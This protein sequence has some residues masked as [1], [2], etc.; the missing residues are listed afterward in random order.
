MKLKI[1]N[2][3]S[4]EDYDNQR[5]DIKKDLIE[6]KKNRTVSIGEHII[7][8]FENYSTIKYQVQEMLR[9]EK[10]FNKKEIQEEI[11]AYNPLIPDGSNFKATML[12]MY[13]DVEERKIMLSKL[14]DIEN[15][16][17]LNCGSKKIV[18][19][20][21]EDLERST[22]NKTSAVHFLRFELDQTDITDFLSNDRVLVGVSHDEYTDEVV[23]SEATKDSLSKD[24]NTN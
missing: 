10:I 23:L 22:D 9:I 7:L 17:Y 18:A 16:I 24:L 6:H 4:L 8:L 3:L 15:N 2:L 20:A 1:E 19:L 13:P 12:I 21:D 11:D 5:E 14:H